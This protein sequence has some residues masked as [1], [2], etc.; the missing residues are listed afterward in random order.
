[1]QKGMTVAIVS[2]SQMGHFIPMSYI[3]EELINRGHN[4]TFIVNNFGK[5]KCTKMVES[6]GAKCITTNDSFSEEDLA[7]T[8]RNDFGWMKLKT[9]IQDI[10]MGLKPDIVVCDFM[11][12]GGVWAAD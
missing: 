11:S 4:V 12:K 8:A 7:P 2:F 9:E 1:M 5:S 6:F 3:G 10:F